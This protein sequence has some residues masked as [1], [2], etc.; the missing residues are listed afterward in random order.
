MLPILWE[1]RQMLRGSTFR[2]L[3]QT[4]HRRLRRRRQIP[5]SMPQVRQVAL[6]LSQLST[7]RF[8]RIL[9]RSRRSLR[10]VSSTQAKNDILGG[11]LISRLL[12]Q[13]ESCP[14]V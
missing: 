7:L 8:L 4:L 6:G 9:H 13:E 1:K 12:R 10:R 5:F 11:K 2:G 14:A 3:Y